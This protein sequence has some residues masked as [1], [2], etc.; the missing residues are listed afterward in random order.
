MKIVIIGASHGGIAAAKS[1]CS[2][3]NDNEIFL[4]DRKPIHELGYISSGINLH[5]Q[6]I[7]H[8]LTEVTT[9]VQPL[10]D[11]GVKL[12]T[13]YEVTDIDPTNHQLI[14]K[15]EQEE[16]LF[17]D[18]LILAMGSSPT[19]IKILIDAENAF[20]YKGLEESQQVLDSLEKAQEVAIFGAGYVGLE[21]ANVL[22]KT[23]RK[24]Y[25]VDNM[26][27][28]L[29]RYFDTNMIEEVQQALAT[30]EIYFYP[31]EFLIDYQ[32]NN[33]QVEKICLLSK[34]ITADTVIFPSQAQPNTEFL[35][36]KV[37]LNDDDTVVVDD[38][39][40]T[41][42][43]DIYAIGD[44]V[45]ISYSETMHVFMPLVT[46]AVHMARAAALTLIGHPTS[47][48]RKNKV[49]ATKIMDYFLGSV[50]VTE[51]EAPFLDMNV[52]SVQAKICLTP[53]YVAQQKTAKVKLIYQK[54]TLE[55]IGA[56]LVSKEYLLQ[57]LNLLSV[58]IHDKKTITELAVENFC[59]VPQFTP[60]FHYLNELA[61]Q[62]L[63]EDNRC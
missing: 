47:F 63:Q 44:I 57:D 18:K 10:I 54:D 2:L 9:D 28:I 6:E 56:Q 15:K 24:V 3:A 5:F 19:N 12:M 51:E 13:E 33:N 27:M 49:S 36:D 34:T 21:L 62:V 31:N 48:D 55:I 7:I 61:L 40:Q 4:I 17:Y 37:A 14:L 46:R 53:T 50:G 11:L 32:K 39:L 23:G 60:H 45:P 59:F 41:S 29:S 42:E 20:T 25:L 26:P 22:A 30:Q 1:L 58:L 52:Q 43:P 8:E 38:Y 35:R 16:I